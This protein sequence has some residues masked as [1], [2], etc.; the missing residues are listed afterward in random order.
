MHKS[1]FS[2]RV[3]PAWLLQCTQTRTV[4]GSSETEH[5]AVAVKPARPPVPSVVTT[6]TAAPRRDIASR[7]DVLET[8]FLSWRVSFRRLFSPRLLSCDGVARRSDR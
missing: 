1:P 7:K 6:F 8:I 2:R 5:T 4:G 3:I